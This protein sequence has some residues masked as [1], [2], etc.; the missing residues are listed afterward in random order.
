MNDNKA[1]SGA[2]GL[3]TLWKRMDFSNYL[4]V[5]SIPGTLAE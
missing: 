3:T 2:E 1:Q 5:Q 4:L